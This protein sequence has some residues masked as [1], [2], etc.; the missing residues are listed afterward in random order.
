MSIPSKYTN[1]INM[2]MLY[3]EN[4]LINIDYIKKKRLSWVS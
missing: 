2:K 3:Y 4:K 1:G